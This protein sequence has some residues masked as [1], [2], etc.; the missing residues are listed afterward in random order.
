MNSFTHLIQSSPDDGFIS[1]SGCEIDSI[2]SEGTGEIQNKAKAS[3][4]ESILRE[5]GSQKLFQL[6]LLSSLPVFHKLL[7]SLCV[8]T[9]PTTE[10]T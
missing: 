4:W 7:V 9:T 10:R 5:R 8:L 2:N 1:V 3:N 6:H